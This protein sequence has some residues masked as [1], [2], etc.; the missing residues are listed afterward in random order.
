MIP[1]LPAPGGSFT[2]RNHTQQL[3]FV[4]MV[5]WTLR[6]FAHHGYKSWNVCCIFHWGI[7]IFTLKLHQ[8]DWVCSVTQTE[9]NGL[10]EPLPHTPSLS[11]TRPLLLLLPLSQKGNYCLPRPLTVSQSVSY[12]L[13][14][15]LSLLPSLADGLSASL[16]LHS[17]IF[18][19]CSNIRNYTIKESL[20]ADCTDE[21]ISQ[22]LGQV[23]AYTSWLHVSV[24]V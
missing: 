18:L 8:G 15:L 7:W 9:W 1:I 22:G 13:H 24:C 6:V 20:K 5:I 17:L 2:H 23:T 19:F 16:Q 21:S 12:A 11:L 10:T 4:T 3:F 14:H